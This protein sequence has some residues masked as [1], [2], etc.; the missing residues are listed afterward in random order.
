[1][2]VKFHQH[3]LVAWQLRTQLRAGGGMVGDTMG[4]GKGM[5]VGGAGQRIQLTKLDRLQTFTALALIVV[6]A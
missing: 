3:C 6:H 1:M 2:P 4:S 5:S